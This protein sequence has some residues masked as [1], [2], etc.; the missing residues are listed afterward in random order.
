MVDGRIYDPSDEGDDFILGVYAKFAE[1]ENRARVR[2]MMMSRLAK[3]E[4]L[5][6]RI[7][8]PTG[9]VWA[10]PEDPQYVELMHDAGLQEWLADLPRRHRAVSWMDGRPFY[11]L[12]F[13][14]VDIVRSIEL[15]IQWLL[16]TRSVGEVY[17][18]IRT[19][20]DWPVPG[21]IPVS[22]NGGCLF[23]S[24]RPPTWEPVVRYSLYQWF[25]RPSLYGTYSYTARS[26]MNRRRRV[27]RG[28]RTSQANGAPREP[29][30]LPLGTT[31]VRVEEAF[32][33]FASPS[34]QA[35][36]LQIL[37]NPSHRWKV[38]RGGKSTGN[39][40]A[41]PYACCGYEIEP[42]VKCG[43]KIRAMYP[44]SRDGG[45]HYRSLGCEGSRVP[46]TTQV[47]SVLDD[48]VL[49][50]LVDVL[51]PTGLQDALRRVRLRAHGL[52]AQRN[53]LEERI[54][55]LE[56]KISAAADLLL[57]A[58]AKKKHQQVALWAEKLERSQMELTSAR[59]DLF[60]V[61]RDEAEILAAAESDLDQIVQLGVD[62]PTLFRRARE[63]EGALQ[64]I[65]AELVERIY[66]RR[67]GESVYE[68]EIAFP[69]GGRVQ[70]V[71]FTG[72]F[73]SVQPARLWAYSRLREGA[74]P[75][76]V[77]G[78][79]T[80]MGPPA[81]TASRWTEPRVRG[82]ALLHEYFETVHP[83]DSTHWSV[84]EIA[85][86]VSTA[87]EDVTTHAFRGRLGPGR[88]REG[89]LMF[90]PTE[91]ELHTW[92]PEYARRQ[93]LQRVG[94]REDDTV[95]VA[96]LATEL[97]L[98]ARTVSERVAYI[99]DAAGRRYTRRSALPASWPVAPD[100]FDGARWVSLESAV[101][102]LG[103]PELKATDFRPMQE[104][105]DDLRTHFG[106]SWTAL[107]KARKARHLTEVRAVGLTRDGRMRRL[108]F[109]HVP[110]AL[111][112]RWDAAS[113]H[114]WLNGEAIDPAGALE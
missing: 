102:A 88:M 66:V 85:Q 99:R 89:E 27:K 42:G 91:R 6:A 43:H 18:R 32:P 62:L 49:D 33:S 71:F 55:K 54:R 14:D 111:A 73:R 90:S 86:Q 67:L 61:Q 29:R 46:H 97:Q 5:E 78:E 110:P 36:V 2:W 56:E 4:R 50:T 59:A 105:F 64:R 72:T 81:K 22:G 75:A 9:L 3:A 82:A 51:R 26:L 40:H 28:K 48:V 8:L 96:V 53:T 21:K 58:Q 69:A 107:G 79:L 11:I 70:R 23:D 77:A 80:R 84:A 93:T 76:E 34:D 1:F 7:N 74:S 95:R 47:N 38:G 41:L 15:R 12:P 63:V 83:R 45:Y 35:R 109:L 100:G 37:S 16:E 106:I 60:T 68:L 25:R 104:V 13:P 20:P 57:A 98:P 31:Q 101:V 39:H 94:W 52:R 19:H 24:E 65:V 92:F 30:K 10:S 113:V 17:R 44:A 114:A 108:Q 87:P 112:N 103:R